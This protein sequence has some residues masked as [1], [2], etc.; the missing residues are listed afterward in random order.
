VFP[1]KFS[2][3]IFLSYEIIGFNRV[4]N[5]SL[6]KDENFLSPLFTI[7]YFNQNQTWLNRN[8]EHCFYKGY[9]NNDYT[10]LISISLCNGLVGRKKKLD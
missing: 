6:I 4:Y 9:V 3:N 1:K 8:I 7:Q 2:S 5:L 10:S